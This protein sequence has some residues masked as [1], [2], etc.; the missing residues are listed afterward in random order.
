[1]FQIILLIIIGFFVGIFVLS[2]GGGGGSFYL[3][4][5]SA[6][7]GLAPAV[8]AATSIVTA[9][10]PLLIGS[11]SYYREKQINF[12]LGNRLLISAIP[13]VV[14]GSLLAPLIPT[15]I[16]KI[17]I[18][19]ILVALGV[20]TLY[21]SRGTSKDKPKTHSKWLSVFFGVISGLMVGIA[22]LSGGGPIMAGL[23]IMGGSFMEASA[24]SSYVL[25]CMAIVGAIFHTSGGNV[26]WTAGLGLMIGAMAGAAVAP[27]LM[28]VMTRGKGPLYL[29]IA[30]GVMILVMGVKTMI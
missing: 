8:A 4:A 21:R 30:M 20:Q 6:V 24:T 12:K 19:L 15:K 11:W 27:H 14:V 2:M 16:Y 10:P 1:M 26:D 29:N 22:G 18:G 9:I 25:I 23:L 7:F 28:K 13:S 17:V 3:G 5:L